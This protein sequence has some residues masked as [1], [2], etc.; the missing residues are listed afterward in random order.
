MVSGGGGYDCN[1]PSR[2]KRI[3]DLTEV[4]GCVRVPS[5][6]SAN[7]VYGWACRC[8]YWPNDNYGDGFTAAAITPPFLNLPHY[9]MSERPLF[10]VHA[11]S[12]LL[13]GHQPALTVEQ[14]ARFLTSFEKYFNLTG[15]FM[16]AYT[17]FGI[18]F[19]S[20]LFF[21]LEH[22]QVSL[23]ASYQESCL[24][25]FNAKS[26]LCSATSAQPLPQGVRCLEYVS[27]LTDFRHCQQSSFAHNG[28][29]CMS[30]PSLGICHVLGFLVLCLHVYPG[31]LTHFCLFIFY[32]V[33]SFIPGSASHFA[34]FTVIWSLGVYGC[35]LIS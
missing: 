13:E 12:D 29:G 22:S 32:Y 18:S 25:S 35:L 17:H 30:C 10:P 26:S 1:P 2:H 15:T 33:V 6:N 27:S 8:A 19:I 11:N 28:R 3:D 31:V 4:R 5:T 34:A 14:L 9:G 23:I 20:L 16:Q 7:I 24:Y 21:R